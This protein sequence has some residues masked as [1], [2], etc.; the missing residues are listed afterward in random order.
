M[1]PIFIGPK[2]IVDA[3]LAYVEEM[4]GLEGFAIIDDAARR[5]HVFVRDEA[6]TI[7][8]ELGPGLDSLF[9]GRA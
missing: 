1:N 6:T 8:G 4:Y 5:L 9:A 3:A 7:E 2:P